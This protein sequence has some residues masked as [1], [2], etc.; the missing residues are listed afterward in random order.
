M[1]FNHCLFGDSLVMTDLLEND[2]HGILPDL[3]NINSPVSDANGQ[4]GAVYWKRGS[5]S[6]TNQLEGSR[7]RRYSA[8]FD[9]D[10]P[11]PIELPKRMS[12]TTDDVFQSDDAEVG[13]GENKDEVYIPEGG[14]N[15]K[16]KRKEGSIA[17]IT[18]VQYLST[19]PKLVNN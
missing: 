18:L 19:R 5:T 16:H 6:N 7:S 2:A 10:L 11:T 13:F 9:P 12:W 15:D 17:N 14:K 4:T 1:I 8:T 3:S